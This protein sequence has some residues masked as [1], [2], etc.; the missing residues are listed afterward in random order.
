M[1]ASEV[2]ARRCGEMIMGKRPYAHYQY[3][4]FVAPCSGPSS[5]DPFQHTWLQRRAQ[6]WR[7]QL[8]L[9]AA[10]PRTT[11]VDFKKQVYGR[12]SNAPTVPH[13]S[14]SLLHT[15]ISVSRNVFDAQRLLEHGKC[16]VCICVGQSAVWCCHELYTL[17]R[18]PKQE[19]ISRETT[20]RQ[21]S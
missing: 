3:H 10:S 9:E 13:T 15:S 5:L 21:R 1:A 11:L 8:D 2:D 19:G 6:P 7:Q 20:V 12:Y 18:G 4:G 14:I 16:G 17:H